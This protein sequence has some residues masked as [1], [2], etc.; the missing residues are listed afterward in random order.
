MILGERGSTKTENFRKKMRTFSP[1]KKI[2]I[3]IEGDSAVE[4][5]GVDDS[6]RIVNELDPEQFEIWYMSY[7]GQAKDWYRVDRFLCRIPYEEVGKVYG[8]CD[9]LIKSSTLESFSYPP[10]EMMATGGYV[11]A[12][13]N[14]G[15]KEFMKDGYNCLIY[16]SKDVNA[17]VEAVQRIVRDERLRNTL[18]SNYD[19][20][21]NS[22][23][24]ESIKYDILALYGVT[25]GG[26]VAK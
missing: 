25:K 1:G 5:K 4:Y 15:N 10:L 16:P 13:Q 24:W 19:E 9:I 11:V 18:Y 17:G 6:F 20:T 21:V 3:L 8:L 2:R 26:K 23:E 12:V 22:R 14:G 7:N